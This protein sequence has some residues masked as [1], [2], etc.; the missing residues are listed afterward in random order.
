MIPSEEFFGRPF[1][2]LMK[3]GLP[4]R[5]NVPTSLAKSLLIPLGLT[6]ESSPEDPGIHGKTYDLGLLVQELQC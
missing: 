2:S 5:K 6:A 1:G 3:A 4:L